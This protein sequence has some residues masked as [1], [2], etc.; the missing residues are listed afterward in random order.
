MLG[1]LRRRRNQ[2]VG[3]IVG[4]VVL[5]LPL[6]WMAGATIGR[7]LDGLS[8]RTLRIGRFDFS[9]D[10]NAN[11]WVREVNTLSGALDSMGHTIETFLRLSQTMATEP[12]VERMLAAVLQELLRAT[13]CSSAVVYLWHEE[14]QTMVRSVAVGQAAAVFEPEVPWPL[15]ADAQTPGQNHRLQLELR[16]RT[17]EL[18]GLLVL[19]HNGE[20]AFRNASF[21]EFA[22]RLSGMLAVSIETRQLI[23]GQKQLLDA[24]IR[25][26]ADAIDAKSPYTGGHCERVP[27]LATQMVDRLQEET[28]GPYASFRLSE[29][30]RYEFHMGAWLHDCGK[31]TS[32]EHIVDKATKLELIYNRIHEVRMRFEVLWR[33]A[34]IHCLEQ[35]AAGVPA[36]TAKAELTA[37]HQRLQD[38]FA[39]VARCNVGSESMADVDLARLQTVGQQTWLRHF[40]DRLGLGAEELQRLQRAQPQAPALPATETLLADRPAHVVPWDERKPPVLK[41]DPRNRYGFD[42]ALPLCKQNMGELHNLAVRRGTLTAEDR[43]KINEHIVQTYMMLHKLPWP[44]HMRRV[45]EIASTHHEKLDGTG[46]P[47]RLAA[48]SL[49]I[50]DRVMALADVFEALTAVDRPYKA[51][52][53]LSESLQIMARMCKEGHLDGELFCY[54]LRNGAWDD[55]AQRY[56]RSEQRDTVDVAALEAQV[57][58]EPLAGRE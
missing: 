13:R 34:Q 31:V 39:F 47:R 45:P 41:N 28:R 14:R 50:P 8:L 19:V 4:M 55:F 10:A 52:K 40:D 26:M 30:E 48:A 25:L 2:L 15:P 35:Q 18:Q 53:P 32:P 5:L 44:R 20:D 56:L 54:F 9:Q 7:S 58:P 46:Y 21:L 57:M 16:G 11:S 42:M 23:E 1:E 22:Q 37:C 29:D 24:V 6:G 36:A 49:S 51:P 43:F 12:H 27:E 17:G 3:L 33:D 38:D